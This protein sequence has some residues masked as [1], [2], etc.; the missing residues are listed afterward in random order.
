MDD[1]YADAGTKNRP[2]QELKIIP[3]SENYKEAF[4]ALIQE[5]AEQHAFT[6]PHK[7][8]DIDALWRLV[9]K[10]QGIRAFLVVDATEKA[11][12][13]VTYYP[14]L[15]RHGAGLYL[16]D[17]VT[18]RSE[19][20]KGIGLF[21]MSKL[22]NVSQIHD[23]SYIAWECARS[24][25]AAQKFYNGIGAERFEDRH[26]WRK[27]GLLKQASDKTTLNPSAYK[28]RA[29][30]KSDAEVVGELL[31]GMPSSN[32][33]GGLRKEIHEE[34]VTKNGDFILAVAENSEG[35]VIGAGIA[36]RSFSTFRIVSGLHVER[37]ALKEQSSA[38][39]VALLDY[40][41]N[42]QRDRGWN[43]HL[44]FTID[45]DAAD[46]WKPVFNRYGLS[47]LEYGDDPMVVRRISG[48][49]MNVLAQKTDFSAV[50]NLMLQ[51]NELVVSKRPAKLR[52]HNSS[53]MAVDP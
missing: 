25:S 17:I 2:F 42:E 48:T 38:V 44:D 9:G 46:F 28:A 31:A 45:N 26:T 29:V 4:F 15:N 51:N 50:E 11:V 40:F 24:N 10:P 20:K 12:G 49:S 8:E 53:T 39:A 22:A 3:V 43:G 41:A 23:A 33:D 18:T 5:Q 32:A 16:E 34:T 7:T 6:A 52:P 1:N 30:K 37:I 14:C 21:A 36:Y 47:P 19:R 35:S 13:T 27:F